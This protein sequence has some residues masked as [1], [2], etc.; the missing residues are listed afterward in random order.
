MNAKRFQVVFCVVLCA[1]R[2]RADFS[3]PK[4]NPVFHF[5]ADHGSHPDFPLEWWYVTGHLVNDQQERFGYQATFFRQVSER[6]GERTTLHLA[7][8]AVLDLSKKKFI[9]QTRLNR[10]GWDAASA[11]GKLNVRNGAWSMAMKDT[12]EN[13]ELIGGV[14]SEASFQLE[15]TPE[16]PLILFGDKGY[17]RK[18]AGADAA[19]YYLTFSRL[20]TRGSLR[21]DGRDLN[22]HGESWMDHEI[23][24]SRLGEGLVGWDWVCIQFVDGREL[25]MYRLR[26]AD[27]GS[28][29]ASTLT[30]VDTSGATRQESFDWKAMSSW[31]SP[32]TKG[33][34]PAQ[35]D[36]STIDPKTGGAAHFKIEPLFLDQELAAGPG[37]IAY[38]EGACR[39]RNHE[40]AEIGSAY[41]ELTGYV[42]PLRLTAE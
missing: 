5:P 9:Y 11:V 30:W 42:K 8:M 34:Y 7:H 4:P 36:L 25:M 33:V 6:S 10:E 13:I 19:S 32:T 1:L 2:L 29:P 38:W 14:K 37:G 22:V 40:G 35:V 28:D 15:L 16:K 23:S 20:Q 39:V 12:S 24:S 17:S 27:G 31:V 41:M 21:I 3:V 18:G 26:S